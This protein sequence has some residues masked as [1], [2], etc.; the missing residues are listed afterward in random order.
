MTARVA[1]LLREAHRL[2]RLGERADLVDL[3]EDRV[4]DAAV[5]AL[6]QPLGI[7]DEEVVADELDPVA[8]LASVSAFHASQSSSA[9]PSSIETIGIRVDDAA[10]E[11]R[12]LRRAEARGPRS[13]RGRREDLARRGVE[14]DRDPL[15]VA[16]ALGRL[17]DR[18]DR[19]LARLEIGREA[20]L[21]ADAGREPAVAEHLLQ[22]V[23]HLGADPQRPRRTTRRRR[24]RP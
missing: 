24:A 21:V 10:P 8:E 14:R 1:V 4:A 17:E 15:A 2:D 23:V 13:G 18:L 16:R 12:H 3:D 6:L 9:Q 7:R 19:G 5:D 11:L 22:R 20:A